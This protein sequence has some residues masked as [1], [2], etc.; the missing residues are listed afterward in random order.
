MEFES[1]KPRNN[2]MVDGHG[3]ISKMDKNGFQNQLP[4]QKILDIH[5]LGM[6]RPLFI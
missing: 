6:T 3:K 5:C 4:G 2:T 1:F